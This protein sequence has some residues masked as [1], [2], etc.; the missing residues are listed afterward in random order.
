MFEQV[1]LGRSYFYPLISQFSTYRG[2]PSADPGN[3][4]VATRMANEVI[5]LPMHHDLSDEDIERTIN[6]IRK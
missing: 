4:P 2:L 3:L 5:C 6:L 1:V